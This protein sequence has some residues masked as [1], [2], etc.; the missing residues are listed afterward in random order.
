MPIVDTHVHLY[1]EDEARY[2]PIPC[3]IR[4]PAGTGTIEHLLK[5]KAEAGVTHVVAVQTGSFYRWDNRLVT[6]LP[7]KLGSFSGLPAACLASDRQAGNA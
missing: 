1:S 4:P 5:V 2:P 7:D 3:P 6:T